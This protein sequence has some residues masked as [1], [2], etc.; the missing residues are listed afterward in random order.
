[1]KPQTQELI[2]DRSFKLL[3]DRA[4]DPARLQSEAD[5]ALAIMERMNMAQL[6]LPITDAHNDKS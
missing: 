5:T 2:V 4:D 3:S 6:A 1:M